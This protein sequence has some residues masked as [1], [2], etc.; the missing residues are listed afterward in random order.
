VQTALGNIS[1]RKEMAKE[2]CAVALTVHLN[3]IKS[4]WRLDFTI[5]MTILDTVHRLE[6]GCTNPGNQT[7]VATIFCIRSIRFAFTKLRSKCS[8]NCISFY[9][10]EYVFSLMM[11]FRVETCSSK[12]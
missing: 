12:S 4:L 1:R 2:L 8:R 9:V 11:T 7:A 6:K 3:A 5:N 10:S